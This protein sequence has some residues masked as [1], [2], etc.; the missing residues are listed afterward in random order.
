M[1]GEYVAAKFGALIVDVVLE[2]L[3]DLCG[4][5]RRLNW[6]GGRIDGDS[7]AAPSNGDG[8]GDATRCSSTSSSS[9]SGAGVT[10]V[11]RGDGRVGVSSYL[12]ALLACLEGDTGILKLLLGLANGLVGLSDV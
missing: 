10:L 3:F 8:A 6:L 11:A 7:E 2:A 5:E 12:L 9:S 1:V 4:V